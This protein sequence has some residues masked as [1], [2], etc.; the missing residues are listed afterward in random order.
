MLAAPSDNHRPLNIGSFT[1]VV[2]AHVLGL[3]GILALSQIAPQVIEATPLYVDFIQPAQPE[4]VKPPEPEPPP[5]PRPVEKPVKKQLIAT[6][7]EP[8][9]TAIETPP[10]PAPPEP[11]PPVQAAAPVVEAPPAPK[12]AAPSSCYRPEFRRKVM[13]VYSER[14]Q[15]LGET[16]HVTVEVIIGTDGK[17]KK[18]TVL[19]SSGFR[20]LDDAAIRSA[21]RSD[22][23]PKELDGAPIESRA[24]IPFDF[25]PP[26][27]PDDTPTA[28][29]KRPC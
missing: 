19:S 14:S 24:T 17:A 15:Q 26:G 7:A 13:P 12:P 20:R 18:A 2:G 27:T 21:M 6:Q 8:T 5:P 29:A 16:G 11:L 4:P 10:E 28:S 1:A 9:P 25:N 3:W 23:V 22:Y